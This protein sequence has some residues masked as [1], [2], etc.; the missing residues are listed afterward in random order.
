MGVQGVGRGGRPRHGAVDLCQ[1]H[2]CR[3]TGLPN[4]STD[5]T[6]ATTPLAFPRT[7]KGATHG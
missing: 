3:V 1:E 4:T 7:C 6:A 2:T 5:T